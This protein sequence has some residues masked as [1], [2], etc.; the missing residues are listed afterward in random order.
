VIKHCDPGNLLK[1]GC[2]GG[3]P[4]QRIR[5]Y[6]IGVEVILHTEHAA[7]TAQSAHISQSKQKA[8]STLR[9]AGLFGTLKAYP[10]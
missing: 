8:D 9:M 4:F 6:D 7:D 5:A 3:L 10:Q 1:K 2:I